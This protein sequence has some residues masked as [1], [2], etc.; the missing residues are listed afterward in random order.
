MQ[1]GHRHLVRAGRGLEAD[2]LQALV[3]RIDRRVL[4]L[5]DGLHV[6]L[7]ADVGLPELLA[8]ERGDEVVLELHVVVTHRATAMLPMLSSYSPSAGK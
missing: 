3:D 1:E 2:A 4:L 8:V 7:A 6:L 5:V